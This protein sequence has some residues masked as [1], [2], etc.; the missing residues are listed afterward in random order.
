M[1]YLM[2]RAKVGQGV[3]GSRKKVGRLMNK[4]L[5]VVL[6]EDEYKHGTI[7]IPGALILR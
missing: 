7:F 5:H 3:V 6:S 1:Q 2:Q 4:H